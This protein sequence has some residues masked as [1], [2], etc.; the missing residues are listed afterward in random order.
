MDL[1]NRLK[2]IASRVVSPLLPLLGR[3]T[4]NPT[5]FYLAK[6]G[7]L[8]QLFLFLGSFFPIYGL[9]DF[10]LFFFKIFVLCLLVLSA[11][12]MGKSLKMGL[13]ESELESAAEA[14]AATEASERLIT[15]G[16]FSFSRNPIY[17]LFFII[18]L[19][20]LQKNFFSI[21]FWVVGGF[22]VYAHHLIVLKEEQYL[23]AK[24]GSQFSD[25]QKRV[26]R[27]GFF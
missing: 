13:P 6:F 4:I 25:Y 18:I 17:T 15:R 24:W 22:T 10:F 21:T 14:K 7:L 11:L 19:L 1:L 12:Q 2:R 8:W 23:R 5:L 26:K 9:G 27:Y 3:P 20:N 16:L